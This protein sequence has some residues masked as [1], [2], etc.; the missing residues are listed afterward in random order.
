MQYIRTLI[1][2]EQVLEPLNRL[3]TLCT[4]A[5]SVNCTAP[6]SDISTFIALIYGNTHFNFAV[7]IIIM[8]NFEVHNFHCFHR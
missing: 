4:G 6:N 1:S 2:Q 3:C 7:T 5:C 8:P